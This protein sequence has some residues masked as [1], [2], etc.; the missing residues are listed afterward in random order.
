MA[1]PVFWRGCLA[2][3]MVAGLSGVVAGGASAAGGLSVSQAWTPAAERG[4]NT[5]LYMV[6]T[7]AGAADALL[8]ARC[9]VANFTE[10]HTVD[11]GEGFPSMRP[12]KSIPIAAEGITQ[13]GVDGN[14]VMLLQ[15]TRALAEGETFT[16]S[17]SFRDAGRQDIEVTVGRPE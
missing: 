12:V 14:H 1:N 9:A 15:T 13:L 3:A 17:I 2:A 16:C 11:Q 5:P 6:V 4:A 7:N 8:R 10:E